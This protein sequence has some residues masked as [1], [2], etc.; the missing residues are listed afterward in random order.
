MLHRGLSADEARFEPHAPVDGV[1]IIRPMLPIDL[2]PH[3]LVRLRAE[4]RAPVLVDCRERWEYDLA[5]LEGALLVPLGEL[6]QRLEDIPP[7]EDVVV[8]CHHGI[9]SRHAVALL[10]QAG[11]PRTQSLAGGLDRWSR[12]IDPT[13]PRY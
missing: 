5:R 6:G 13:V 11:L 2:D 8:Y 1:V 10:R 3:E 7:E 12:E 4:G 9:R